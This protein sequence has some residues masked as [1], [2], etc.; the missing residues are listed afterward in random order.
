MKIQQIHILFFIA[1]APFFGTCLGRFVD[2]EQ[3]VQAVSFAVLPQEQGTKISKQKL[4]AFELK[5]QL[6]NWRNNPYIRAFLAV[7]AYAELGRENALRA[8]SYNMMYPSGK[9]FSGFEQHPGVVSCAESYG[10]QLCSTAAGRY[11]FLK[12]VWQTIAKRLDLHDF[13]PLNQDLAAIYLIYEKKAIDDIKR[14]DLKAA[15]AKVN[16]IWSSLPGSP[17]NQPVKKYKKLEEFFKTRAAHY[18][19]YLKEKEWT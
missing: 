1:T 15:L 10:K 8:V 14:G 4:Q 9:V 17:H 16:T 2:E 7:I 12:N 13:S 18:K 11:M 3:S 5:K 6:Y 19:K